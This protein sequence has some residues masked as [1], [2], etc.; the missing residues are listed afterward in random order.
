MF[1]RAPPKV[2][3]VFLPPKFQPLFFAPPEPAQPPPPPG[4]LPF[5]LGHSPFQCPSSPQMKHLPGLPPLGL[6]PLPLAKDFLPPLLFPP[7]ALPLPPFP[8]ANDPHRM[9]KRMGSQ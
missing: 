9:L 3:Q 1:A 8:F 7:F 4:P 5:R 6:F 2:S